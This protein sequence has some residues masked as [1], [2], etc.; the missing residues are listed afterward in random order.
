MTLAAKPQLA[1]RSQISQNFTRSTFHERATL[2]KMSA[3]FQW[4]FFKY[5]NRAIGYLTMSTQLVI[6]SR[7]EAIFV[8]GGIE[9]AF[10]SSTKEDAGPRKMR[11]SLFSRHLCNTTSPILVRAACFAALLS[12]LHN[13]TLS[14][15]GFSC[16]RSHFLVMP[17]L[18][19]KRHGNFTFWEPG[20]VLRDL[21]LWEMGLSNLPF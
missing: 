2:Y 8:W 21:V 16:H 10:N 11:I 14:Y 5:E 13:N 6:D 19:I 3:I 17:W 18:I 7:L 4:L 20:R 9:I 12:R 1:T 15:A